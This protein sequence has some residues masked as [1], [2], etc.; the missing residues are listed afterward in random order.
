[1]PYLAVASREF[2]RQF[3][4]EGVN[5]G[6]LAVAPMITFNAKDSLQQRFMRRFGD[7]TP[8]PPTHFIPSSNGFVEGSRRGIGWCMVP[9]LLVKQHLTSGELV[10]IAPG[11]TLDVALY[12]QHWRMK[13][14]ILSTFTRAVRAVAHRLLKQ[15]TDIALAQIASHSIAS[16]SIVNPKRSRSAHAAKPSAESE[17]F[18]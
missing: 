6:S 11:P 1:M 18:L 16:H 4:S 14:Q 2:A 12:L 3:F 13:S 15:D 7:H 17:E 10:N 9:E 8:A 5:I